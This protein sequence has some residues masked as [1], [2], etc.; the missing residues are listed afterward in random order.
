MASLKLVK[1]PRI[2]MSFMTNIHAK[3]RLVFDNISNSIF[4]GQDEKILSHLIA[5]LATQLLFILY[6]RL[7]TKA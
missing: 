2:L 1:L 5:L 7:F 3:T 4:L 6:V